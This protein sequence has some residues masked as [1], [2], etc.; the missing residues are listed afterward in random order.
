MAV[1]QRSRNRP[2]SSIGVDDCLNSD[3]CRR[4][5]CNDNTTRARVLTFS[6]DS[7]HLHGLT[8]ALD[9]AAEKLAKNDDFRGILCLEN[10]NGRH[11]IMVISLWD[12]DGLSDTAVE[13]E[14]SRQLIEVAVDL[15]VSSKCYRVLGFDPGAKRLAP[16]LAHASLSRHGT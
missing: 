3:L 10:E 1:L 11:E 9:V 16:L 6:V 2:I 8:R 7:Q 14:I 13:A 5:N 4:P 15:G 12:G